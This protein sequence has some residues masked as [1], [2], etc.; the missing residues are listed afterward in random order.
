[1]RN[2]HIARARALLFSAD[3]RADVGEHRSAYER[4]AIPYTFKPQ[5]S[6]LE[7]LVAAAGAFLRVLLGCLSF[8][9]W[10]TYSLFAWSMIRNPFWRIGVQLPLFL[11]F[12]LSFVLIMLAIA[13]LVRAASQGLRSRV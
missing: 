1:M 10:G 6:F 12:I 4:C 11:S 13:A 5:L 8:A 9:V 3:V 7:A 2:A